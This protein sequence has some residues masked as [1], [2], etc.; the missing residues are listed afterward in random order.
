MT[1]AALALAAAVLVWPATPRRSVALRQL[2]RDGR[3][4][5][6]W[7]MLGLLGSV[8]VL[9]LPVPAVLAL[10]TLAG[11]VAL[12]RRRRA[13]ERSRRAESAALQA[14]LEVLVGELRIGAHPVGAFDT[15]AGEV[16]GPVG[17]G[18]RAVS[19]R[20]RLGAD[21]AAGLD[22][23]AGQSR[24]PLHWERLAVCWRLAHS[25]GLSI[26][27]LMHTAQQDIVERERFSARVA[28]AMAGPRTTAAVLAGLPV[29]GIGLGELIGAQPLAFLLAPGIGGWLLVIGVLLACGGLLWS[30]EITAGALK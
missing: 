29:A 5:R 21:V 27:A 11:T 9:T 17:A 23:V 7:P 16:S 30:D 20:A 2:R 28:S 12:R 15:A 26:A 3:R 14:A 24:L 10:A 6:A 25:H 19:A 1:T 4:L 8:A 13:E 22:D 18:L